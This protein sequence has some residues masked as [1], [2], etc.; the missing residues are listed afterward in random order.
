MTTP[1]HRTDRRTLLKASAALA[2]PLFVHV[3][4][5]GTA[6]GWGAEGEAPPC[7]RIRMAAIG[8]GGKGRHNVGAMLASGDVE[9][10]WRRRRG[11]QP[12]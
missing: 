5:L 8:T 10:G 2:G 4:A 9:T 6:R 12:P 7:E 3:G 11:R 1:L